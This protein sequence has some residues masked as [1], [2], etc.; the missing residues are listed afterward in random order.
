M[1]TPDPSPDTSPRRRVKL[2]T[3]NDSRVWDDQGTGHVTSHMTSDSPNHVS[4]RDES[5]TG[6]LAPGSAANE[7]EGDHVASHVTDEE[8]EAA[9]RSGLSLV[10]HSETQSKI[11]IIYI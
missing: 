11:K 1:A 5:S 8:T 4:P 6:D 9:N 2:Y 3:L 7:T 10:V